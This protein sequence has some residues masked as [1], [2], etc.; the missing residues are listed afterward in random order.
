MRLTGV[1][2]SNHFTIFSS[3]K[4]KKPHFL[5]ADTKV[6]R[7]FSSCVWQ[8]KWRFFRIRFLF[9]RLLL[10]FVYT[11]WINVHTASNQP[12]LMTKAYL[13]NQSANINRLDKSLYII[14]FKAKYIFFYSV[15]FLLYSA[16]LWA[17]H[18]NLD[19]MLSTVMIANDAKTFFFFF[20]GFTYFWNRQ[21]HWK[22]QNQCPFFSFFCIIIIAGYNLFDCLLRI[23]ASSVFGEFSLWVKE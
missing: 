19:L 6:I 22:L 1:V 13:L 17:K 14:A 9:A 15:E 8:L 16:P 11:I 23:F 18:F 20:Y 10:I 5:P 12:K 21:K 7:T 4:D 2:W 3:Q